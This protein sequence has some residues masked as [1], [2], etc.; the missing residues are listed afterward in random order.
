LDD[1]ISVDEM[2]TKEEIR[3]FCISNKYMIRELHIAMDMIIIRE[4]Q[5]MKNAI[6]D[7]L[8]KSYSHSN[9]RT[10]NYYRGR[11]Y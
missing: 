8:N 11:I 6:D 4:L 2:P 7:V 10:R 9:Y 1:F 5:V 3:Q